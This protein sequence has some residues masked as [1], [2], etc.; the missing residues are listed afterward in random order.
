M[1]APS[2]DTIR[3][4]KQVVDLPDLS[5]TK[6][7]VVDFIARGGMGAVYRVHDVELDRDAAL[8]VLSV[9][10]AGDDLPFD[11]LLRVATTS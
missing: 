10:D 9:P 2:D 5:G 7:E 3:H 11:W 1:S 6:Y 4:L 8:K